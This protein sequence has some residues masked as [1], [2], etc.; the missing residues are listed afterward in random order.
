MAIPLAKPLQNPQHTRSDQDTNEASPYLLENKKTRNTHKLHIHRLP[1]PALRHALEHLKQ[2]AP[3]LA[4][5]DRFHRLSQAT[6]KHKKQETWNTHLHTLEQ[7]RH[8]YVPSP[9]IRFQAFHRNIRRGHMLRQLPSRSIF[10]P[11]SPCIPSPSTERNDRQTCL[12]FQP[13]NPKTWTRRQLQPF[14]EST[15][16][17]LDPTPQTHTLDIS[18][19]TLIWEGEAFK[20]GN[21]NIRLIG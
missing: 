2:D 18:V 19:Y 11:L 15:N 12:A 8:L 17:T 21:G 20:T 7:P 3:S 10:Q 9:V 4:Y 14:E 5:R 16:A 6:C 1:F 13:I